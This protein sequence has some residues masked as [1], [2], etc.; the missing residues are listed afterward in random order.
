[1]GQR[2]ARQQHETMIS[3]S[4]VFLE[5]CTENGKNFFDRASYRTSVNETCVRSRTKCKY[6][7]KR[8][9]TH[10]QTVARNLGQLFIVY[11]HT[12]TRTH[13]RGWRGH[14]G[15]TTPTIGRVF[16]IIYLPE[17]S[18]ASVTDG[19]Y[20]RLG[21]NLG[22]LGTFGGHDYYPDEEDIRRL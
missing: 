21:D 2:Q 10:G 5:R 12:H 13:A 9:Q 6:R 22:Q 18:P 19:E 17:S 8:S 7:F 16:D 14:A 4:N 3:Q 11:T 1:M 15:E 20:R